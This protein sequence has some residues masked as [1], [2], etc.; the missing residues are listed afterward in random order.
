M[1][2]YA[3]R[4][5]GLFAVAKIRDFA[6]KDPAYQYVRPLGKGGFG[7]VELVRRKED[8]KVSTP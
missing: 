4:L 8:K 7:R 5:E 2:K 6:G 3:D 1:I